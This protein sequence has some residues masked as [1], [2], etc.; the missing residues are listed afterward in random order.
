MYHNFD[1]CGRA[2][3][4]SARVCAR[5]QRALIV[6]MKEEIETNR[7][8]CKKWSFKCPVVTGRSNKEENVGKKGRFFAHFQIFARTMGLTPAFGELFFFKMFLGWCSM[9]IQEKKNSHAA[10]S[11]RN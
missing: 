4:A 11:W 1:V 10:F 7:T 8:M 5:T 9:S 3:A 2:F 6:R